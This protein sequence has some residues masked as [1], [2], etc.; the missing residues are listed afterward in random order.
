M[1][2]KYSFINNM[3]Y[4]GLVDHENM[5]EFKT[6]NYIIEIKREEVEK[7]F[8]NMQYMFICSLTFK[9]FTGREVLRISF[10]ESQAAALI[11]SISSFVYDNYNNM[12]AL[13]NI[14]GSTIVETYSISLRSI[15]NEN[16][17][18]A[19][20]F[21]I[22]CYNSYTQQT[23]PILTTVFDL[24]ELDNLCDMMFFVYLID[25]ASDREG[26]YGG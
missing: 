8:L 17:D 18:F 25:I 24:D 10:N 13:S 12:I 15:E 23:V 11:D 5:G 9:D 19:I 4:S 3:Y 14:N 26:I 7:E 16:K 1:M 20:L 22:L 2:N 6:K 21:Q